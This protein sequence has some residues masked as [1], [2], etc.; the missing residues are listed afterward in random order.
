[1]ENA[2]LEEEHKTEEHSITSEKE[3][4]ANHQL[5]EQIMAF[6]NVLEH[7]ADVE[8]CVSSIEN[9]NT[10]EANG[11][12]DKSHSTSSL[13]LPEYN[14]IEDSKLRKV[15]GTEDVSYATIVGRHQKQNELLSVQLQESG[16]AERVRGSQQ[17]AEEIADLRKQLQLSIMAQ[18]AS[19]E[20]ASELQA[21]VLS[22]EQ[23]AAEASRELVEVQKKLEEE[24]KARDKKYTELDVKFGKLQKRA[25]QRIQ[26]MQKEKEDV[27]AQLAAALE[28]TSQAVSQCTSLQ[29]DLERVRAQAGDALRSLDA[30]RQQLRSTNSKQKE[31][32]EDLH[33]KLEATEL[34]QKEAQRVASEKEQVV[35]ELTDKLMEVEKNHGALVADLVF[36]HQ[37]VVADLEA[38]LGDAVQE[39]TKSAESVA[40]LQMQLAKKESHI[41]ELDAASSGEVIRLTAS[42]DSTRAELARME[43][44][45]GKEQKL[46]TAALETMKQKLEEAEKSYLQQQISAAKEKSQVESEFQGLQH[47]LSLA[48]AELLASREQV[49]VLEKEFSAYKVRA[50]SLL[51]KKDAELS[52]A[53]DT[54]QL[55]AQEAALKEAQRVAASAAAERDSAIKA[56][57][58]A[59]ME[60]DSQLAARGVALMDAQQKIRELAANLEASKARMLL[61]QEAWQSRV[62]DISKA[63]QEKYNILK[64]KDASK[65]ALEEEVTELRENYTR[66]RGEYDMFQDMAN[67]MLESK[68]QEIAR[69][70]EEIREMQKIIS[71]APKASKEEW[72]KTD[73]EPAD[74]QLSVGE[75]QILI[76]ARQQAQREEELSQCQRH[77]QALQD[78]IVEL[79]HE[80]RLHTQQEAALKEELRNL[81]RSKKREGVDMTY[82]KNVILKLLETGEVEALLPVVA[83]LLQFSRDELKKCQEVYNVMPEAPAADAPST[84]FSRFLFSK[85]GK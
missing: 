78:E 30:E 29:H 61:E 3:V 19:E 37:K 63:W 75:Q 15:N 6:P 45:H 4:V 17:Q 47:T 35:N 23:K 72:S 56:L 31:V 50:H 76:L 13:E 53:K 21:A 28:K 2:T 27:E 16:Q 43:Q 69:L 36:K 44:E 66:I 32:I 1:M 74:N 62:D 68:D 22:A 71:D 59:S 85:T 24:I 42:L 25:K 65:V 10:D 8:G 33:R 49:A 7:A 58:E 46:W 82:L 79:E 60:H 67:N 40:S 11:L 52:A 55:A 84:L 81:E 83:M 64:E 51:Q 77:I 20:R 73:R 80:N 34:E 9:A 54:E 48:Q 26:E 18:S 57:Q 5:S 12:E 70:L 38:Q 41:A 39:R 14:F